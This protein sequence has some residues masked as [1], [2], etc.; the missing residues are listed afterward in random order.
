MTS[1]GGG[2]K[3]NMKE[4]T[5]QEQGTRLWQNTVIILYVV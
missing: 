4:S 1:E 5:V 2:G 3:A